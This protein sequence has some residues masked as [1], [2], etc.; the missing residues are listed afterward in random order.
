MWEEGTTDVQ[1]ILKPNSLETVDLNR[2]IS[3]GNQK[4][5]NRD[6]S[7]EKEGTYLQLRSFTV[8]GSFWQPS[9]DL[10]I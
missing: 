6:A 8:P 7:I 1:S 10:N 2:T 3:I 4:E 9:Y 5:K